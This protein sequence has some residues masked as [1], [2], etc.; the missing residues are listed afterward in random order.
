MQEKQETKMI[1]REKL[2]GEI[3]LL[4][5]RQNNVPMGR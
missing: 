3:T 1:R 5:A 4:T 2:E